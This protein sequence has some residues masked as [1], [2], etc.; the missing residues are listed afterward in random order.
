VLA[1]HRTVKASRNQERERR[2]ERFLADAIVA[3]QPACVENVNLPSVDHIDHGEQMPEFDRGERVLECF[4]RS[5]CR[6]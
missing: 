1:L 3:D 6:N 5:A 4:S 2:F